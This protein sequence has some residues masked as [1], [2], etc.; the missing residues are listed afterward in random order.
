MHF[1]LRMRHYHCNF[2][3]S[4]FDV[5]VWA[6]ITYED[7]HVKESVCLYVYTRLFCFCFCSYFHFCYFFSPFFNVHFFLNLFDYFFYAL[8]F[9]NNTNTVLIRQSF[10]ASFVLISLHLPNKDDTFFNWYFLYDETIFSLLF[11]FKFSVIYLFSLYV[12]YKHSYSILF[13]KTKDSLHN[14]LVSNLFEKNH[15]KV[16]AKLALTWRQ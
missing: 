11:F 3:F 2:F 1:F 9:I 5:A 10:L 7:L 12:L 15:Q 8:S 14:W 13:V 4:H 16:I 6:Q